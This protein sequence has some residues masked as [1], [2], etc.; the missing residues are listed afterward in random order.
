MK[1]G[2]FISRSE[3]KFWVSIIGGVIITVSSFF[4]LKLDVRDTQKDIL[5][6]KEDLAD[7]KKLLNTNTVSQ[8]N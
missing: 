3:I 1:T 6:I 7:V 8:K 2:N 4:N 5:Q